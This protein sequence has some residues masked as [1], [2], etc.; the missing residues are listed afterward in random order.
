VVLH[1]DKDESPR[2]SENPS[3]AGWRMRVVAYYRGFMHLNAVA[4]LGLY[5]RGRELV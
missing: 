1:R 4:K 2:R 3:F 5:E